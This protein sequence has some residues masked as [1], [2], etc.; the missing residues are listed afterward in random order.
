M[1]R[2]QSGLSLLVAVNKPSGMSSHDVVNTCRR[3]FEE[4]RVGHTGTLDPLTTGLL[5]ICIG[6]ATKLD[7]FLTG[8]DKRYIARIGFGYETTTDDLAGSVTVRGE[9]Q[10]HL[11]DG[12]YAQTFVE[13][14]RG[15]HEQLP[16]QYSAIKVNGQRAY[17]AA[18]KGDHVDL[19]F[20]T[21]QI[22]EA[23][24]LGVQEDEESGLLCWDVEF[25][26]SKGTYIRSL[27]RDIGR[28]EKKNAELPSDFFKPAFFSDLVI[29]RKYPSCKTQ[30]KIWRKTQRKTRYANGCPTKNRLTAAK[31]ISRKQLNSRKNAIQTT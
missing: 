16:P 8:H 5:P 11:L 14:L 28:D 23:R 18:R 29:L 4:K 22:H 20:R 10:P 15:S 17:D 9:L 19:E 12:R 31:H 26:V 13:N 21:I 25:F 7:R 3:I 30:R 2:G 27:A 1:K 24:L 6:P